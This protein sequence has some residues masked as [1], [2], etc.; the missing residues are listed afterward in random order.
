VGS[1]FSTEPF[2]VIYP[3]F[4]AQAERGLPILIGEIDKK[5]PAEMPSSDESRERL[6]KRQANAAVA[7]LRMN[8]PAKV[9]PLLKHSPD[10]RARSYLI[11]RL[12]PLGADP[13]A[14][15]RQ[16]DEESD[17][18]IRRA[19][20][21]SLG[22][23]GEQDLS[24]DERKVLTTKLQDLYR[25]AA[26]PGLHA[27]V[28]WLLRTWKEDA[29]LRDA[30][31]KWAKDDTWRTQKLNAV[32][33]TLPKETPQTSPSLPLT[34]S[35]SFRDA[36]PS[37]QWY[38]NG[39]SQT[40]VVIPGPVEFVMG[41]PVTEDKREK[42]ERQHKVR[43]G[44]TFALAAKAVTFEQYRKFAKDYGDGVPDVYTR[45]PEQPVVATS[46]YQAAAYC[47]W[48]SKQEGIPEDHWCYEVEDA[49]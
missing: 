6:A 27:A 38:V 2:A 11:H 39:Q 35:A 19:L 43:I 36:V 28:E 44:R 16:F 29:W 32:A 30:N 34:T 23:F 21:L 7:L 18:S 5:L 4:K 46:W 33:G 48:L 24:P 10:P 26:D 41:S 42:D 49:K 37:P 13:K 3:R 14:I 45:M 15:I 20:I 31:D 8:Q 1:W 12:S 9:W 40:M 47:N 25:T 22:E 17:V